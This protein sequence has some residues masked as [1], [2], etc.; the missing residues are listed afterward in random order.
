[1]KQK[2]EHTYLYFLLIYIVNLTH[3]D[4][5]IYLYFIAE[6]EISRVFNTT[7]LIHQFIFFDKYTLKK[8]NQ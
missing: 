2:C 6:M 7:F 8:L 5:Y 1:M 3:N 4:E